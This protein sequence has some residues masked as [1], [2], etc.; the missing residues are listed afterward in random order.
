M[1][2]IEF[3]P[4]LPGVAFSGRDSIWRSMNIDSTNPTWQLIFPSTYGNVYDI[5][6]CKA[7]SNILYTVCGPNHL[8]R[9]DNAMAA[10]PNFNNLAIPGSNYNLYSGQLA[11]YGKN[12]NVVYLVR[13]DSIYRSNDK[14]LSWTNITYNLPGVYIF[15]IICD[16]YSNNERVFVLAGNCVYYKDTTT[17]T[18]T[19]YSSAYGLPSIATINKMMLYSD[20]TS[21]SVLRVATFGR[22]VWECPINNNMVPA[23]DFKSDKQ[24]ICTGDTIH[25]SKNIYNDTSFA[26]SFPGGTPS[27]STADSPVIVYNTVGTYNV[28]LRASGQSGSDTVTKTGYINVSNGSTTPFTEGFEGAAYPPAGWQLFSQTGF[29]WQLTNTAGGFGQS[30]HC[31]VFDN[32]HGW[33]QVIMPMLLLF[34]Q[35]WI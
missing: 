21:A 26:W 20:G 18:W 3:N 13:E 31:I 35:K 5:A 4:K 14:G 15:Q 30:A 25:F 16:D 28:S 24:Y 1:P 19:N 34:H 8:F 32:Y 22:G 6:S 33:G 12:P 27:S 11:T 29:N 9:S 17:N 2:A 10:T 23:I 7:D